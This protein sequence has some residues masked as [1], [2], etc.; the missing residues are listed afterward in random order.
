MVEALVCTQ[1]WLRASRRISIILEDTFRELE[2]L[3]EESLKDLTIEQPIIA[4]D[5]FVEEGQ[6]ARRMEEESRD[7]GWSN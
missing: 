5:E 7:F 3:E 6:E 4:I 1:D 2:I